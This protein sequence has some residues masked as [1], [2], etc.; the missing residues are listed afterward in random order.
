M[1]T[2]I[3]LISLLLGVTSVSTAA[4]TTFPTA[5]GS[6]TLP[7]A[8]TVTGVFDGK[9]IRFGRGKPCTGQVEG[10]NNDAVFLLQDGATLKNAIIG[11]DQI[12]GVHCLGSCTIQN[13]WWEDVC[14]DAL[15]LLQTSGT[16][17]VIG[18]GANNAEDKVIQ[19]NGGGT[20]VIQDFFV[21]DFGKFYRSCGN[22][23]SGE[24]M[25]QVQ[26]SGVV[27]K[28]GKVL[29]G[30]NENYGDTVTIKNTCV[31]NVNKVCVRYEGN[32]SGAEPIELGN[33]PDSK[34]CLYS[35][36]DITSC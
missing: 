26:I 11:A 4:T 8:Q 3:V 21:T 6:T 16:S 13:V 25:R 32:S 19:H 18:G 22:C 29:A 36:S 31:T 33:G 10:G 35:A 14:E 12:E 17:K 9:M 5:A 20:V 2:T 27:A 7:S 23:K 34:V 1:Q 24:F 28:N 30:A 15:T